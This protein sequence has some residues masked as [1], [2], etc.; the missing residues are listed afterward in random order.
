MIAIILAGGIGKRLRGIS[1]KTS[2]AMLP[3]LGVP[4]IQKIIEQIL[5]ETPIRRFAIVVRTLDQDIAAFLRDNPPK[6]TEIELVC[7]PDPLGMADAV[8]KVAEQSPIESDFL[9][10][11]SDNLYERG[12]VS[13]LYRIHREG[14]FDGTLCLLRMRK[15]AIA[16]KSAAVYLDSGRVS[17]I[18]EKPPLEEIETDV[19]CIPLYIFTPKLLEYV[20]RVQLSKR[21][22]Y[23]LQDAIQMLIDDGGKLGYTITN[24]RWT[25]T[26][27]EDLLAINLQ[28]L[29]DRPWHDVPEIPDVE[30]EQ[31]VLIEQPCGLLS[32]SHI[33]P[34]VYIGAGST[35]GRD[36]RLSN[37]LVLPGSSVPDATHADN[38]VLY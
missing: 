14:H 18:V 12:A 38:E 5:D 36:C 34:N 33:G 22:E 19:A 21:G 7:Q 29:R 25:I 10:T 8:N 30:I 20:P 32:G 17:R 4:I 2:K 24:Q 26:R 23:E 6:G 35:I 3:I 13:E 27:P 15:E 1:Q 31:P 9:L 28:M 11:A 16:E 37:C